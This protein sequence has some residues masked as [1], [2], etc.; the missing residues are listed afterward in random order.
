MAN[1]DRHVAALLLE[2]K[3]VILAPDKPF[4]WASGWQSPIY[5]DNRVTLSFP[6]MRDSIKEAFRTSI[7]E[8]FPGPDL[9]AG[10]ATGAI[11]QGALVAD[12]MELPFIYVRPSA[13]GHGR[14]NLIEGR[15]H[16]GQKVVVIED[17]I[18][19]G[20]SSLKAV[21]AL[22][23]AGAEVLGMVAIFSYGFE[24]AAENFRTSGVS[25]LTLTN[26]HM[27]IETALETGAIQQDQVEMLKQWRED[28]SQWKG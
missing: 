22:R 28:P 17:L 13:K 23:E 11:A 14:Q 6:E 2:S 3:A 1:T 12:S 16:P 26:Y 24:L 19:T 10:V 20:G 5:C 15:M 4:T 25:L 8:Y 18:S 21:E 27:L 9:I 7:M